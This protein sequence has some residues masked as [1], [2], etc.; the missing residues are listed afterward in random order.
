MRFIA[1][2]FFLICLM[3]L[4]GVDISSAQPSGAC[5]LV[6]ERSSELGCWIIAHDPLGR[7]A[8]AQ[9]YWHLDTFSNRADAEA[10]KGPRG[11]VVESMG[12]LWLFTIDAPGWRATKG[13]RVAEIG[14]LPITTGGDYSAQYMEA[15]FQPGMTSATHDH[16]GPEAWYT[17]EGETCLETPGGKQIGRANGAP[18]IV[19]DGPMH[20]TATGTGLRRALVLILHDS[21]KPSSA[22]VH[23]WHPKGLCND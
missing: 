17:L 19:P 5:R 8:E 21:S 9:T 23:H 22:L 1:R 16:S 4:V 11:T 15:I 7:F 18:V 12:R 13:K 10:A 20:L 14:P 6:S 3:V 2:T